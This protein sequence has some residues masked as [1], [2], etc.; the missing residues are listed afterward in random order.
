MLALTGNWGRK[1]TGINCWAVGLFD[2]QTL[3]MA[4][5]RAG[6][7]GAEDVLGGLSALEDMVKE[8]DPTLSDELAA[9]EVWRRLP[10]MG[11]R[12]MFPAFFFWYWH[13]GYKE[14]WN[15]REWNDPSMLRTFEEYF[16]E[17]MEEGWWQLSLIHISEP[18]RPY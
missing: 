17:A 2:G 5:Q 6:I 14:R 7:E 11:S 9:I 1:G 16:D 10:T 13:A 8:E 4:K 12:A 18:T 15:T 3:T